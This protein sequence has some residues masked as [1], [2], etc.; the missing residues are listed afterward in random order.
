MSQS[1][2]SPPGENN[3]EAAS[4]SAV[5]AGGV[6]TLITLGALVASHSAVVMADFFKTLIEFVAVLLSWMVL[7][8]IRRGQAHAYDYGIGKLENL[9][10][11]FVSLLMLI[12]LGIVIFNAIYNL[13]HPSHISG[14][15]IWIS[16]VAQV[17]YAG[18]NGGL[19]FKSRRTAAAEGSPV[20]AS[21]ARLFLSKTIANV[22]ILL[23]LVLS[24]SLGRFSWAHYIDP[25]ASL[26]I[27]GSILL[28]AT[29]I[30]T[31]SCRDLLDRTLEEEHQLVI[32]RELTRYFH[33]YENL[34]DI[35]SRRS[36][37]RVFIE[38]LLE[39]APDRKVGEVQE[40]MERMCRS[41]ES[42]IL[43]S[44]VTIGLAKSARGS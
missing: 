44:R 5:L 40:V 12:C 26:V 32:L 7:R 24:L 31:L 23:S 2:H 21:Q 39:F 18:I 25:L 4:R 1:Q 19:C 43:N 16:L 42:Q 37:S 28:A 22:F 38:I 8:R 15:G 13:I 29:G 41:L 11:L 33:E 6:D 27:A 10:S 17:V 20:M 35:R 3:K 36:G 30:F 34:H 9:S 14:I